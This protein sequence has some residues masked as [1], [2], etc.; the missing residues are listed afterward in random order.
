[1]LKA[2]GWLVGGNLM[3]QLLRLV[4]NLILTRL[5]LPEAFGLVAAVNTLYF[6]LVM[7]SDFG[8]WQSVVRSPH[9]EQARFLG[10]AWMVQLLRGV[11]LCAIVLMIALVL[12]WGASAG[13]FASGTVYTD[14]RLPLMMAVFS[15][16]ALIQ[17]LESMKL[18]LAQREL[19]GGRLARLEIATQLVAMCVTLSLAL[20]TRSVWSLLVGTLAASATR[21]LMSH[22]YLPGHSARPCWDA[23]YATEILGF[24]KWIFVS[25][26]IGFLAA[27]GEKLILGGTLST[28]MFG[29][30]SIAST[31]LAAVI[32]L[33]GALN[34]HVIFSSLSLAH[35]SDQA[36]AAKVYSKVQQLADVLLAGLAGLLCTS[37]QW[38]VWLLYD[39]RYHEAGWM[40]QGLGL[41]LLA[42]RYQVIEQYMFA[43][44]QPAWVSANNGL[45]ALS[46]LLLVPLGYRLGQAPGAI[47]GVV[48]SQFASWP[49]SLWFKWR[50]G[51]LTWASEAVWLPVLLAGVAL[52]WLLD[53]GLRA[54][55]GHG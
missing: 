53:M 44:G 51:L 35:R 38:V 2:A 52:G 15:F 10:T 25:S 30:F 13:W 46:L 36:E 20:V 28:P 47:A 49:L 34:A 27:H 3:S 45:R 6:A 7:F 8:I 18:A 22:F 55:V 24:G 23:G 50:H 40:L 5:L 39:T 42:I 31:L 29:I 4:S 48:L 41:T 9:G 1:M 14:A 32:G 26:I 16:S 33:Y 21:T 19:Q 12:H 11:L 43:H 37:G 54:G 17:G